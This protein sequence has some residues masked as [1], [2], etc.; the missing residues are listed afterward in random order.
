ME[1]KLK[2]SVP[3]L[4]FIAGGFCFSFWFFLRHNILLVTGGIIWV[5]AY[6]DVLANNYKRR[7]P[8]HT[9]G[10]LVTYEKDPNWYKA[11]YGLMTFLGLFSLFVF[12]IL[13]VFGAR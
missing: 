7:A 8:I 3:L 4:L 2:P 6:F 12:L 5:A 9:R 1:L 10:G 13:N 11:V